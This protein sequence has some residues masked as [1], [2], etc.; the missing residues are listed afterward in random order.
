MLDKDENDKNNSHQQEA[1]IILLS[2]D[3]L[4]SVPN[5]K[6]INTREYV[7]GSSVGIQPQKHKDLRK[8]FDISQFV[9]LFSLII[10]VKKI[11]DF[12]NK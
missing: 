8:C 10:L 1:K 4:A 7:A 3:T 9:E 5:R 6:K 11:L 12:I 2:C